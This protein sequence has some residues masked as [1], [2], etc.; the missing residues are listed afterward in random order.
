MSSEPMADRRTSEE[1]L[2]LEQV[3]CLANIHRN[4]V[5]LEEMSEGIKYSLKP[6]RFIVADL[7][8]VVKR[9]EAKDV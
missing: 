6:T 2:Y 7:D 3:S 1:R 9:W 4:L 8:I 5:A